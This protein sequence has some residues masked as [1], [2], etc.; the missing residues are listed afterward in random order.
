[1]SNTGENQALIRDFWN[2]EPEKKERSMSLTATFEKENPAHLQTLDKITDR[3]TLVVPAD[4]KK[5][6]E[7][8]SIAERPAESETTRVS[9][10]RFVDVNNPR[11]V[12]EEIDL[13]NV[14]LTERQKL[15]LAGQCLKTKD[16]WMIYAMQLLSISFGYYIINTYKNFGETIPNLNDDKFL[17]LVSSISALFNALRFMWSG[18]LD[19]LDFKKVYGFLCCLQVVLACTVSLT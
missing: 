6:T 1:M 16:F 10:M 4:D 18:A 19:K 8:G 14:V 7:N 2:Q 3:G 11:K 9:P 13:D 12:K 5:K 17:T 15:R